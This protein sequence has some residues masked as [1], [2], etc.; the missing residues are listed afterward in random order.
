MVG[1][2][3]SALVGALH[4][5]CARACLEWMMVWKG[6]LYVIVYCYCSGCESTDCME[7]RTRAIEDSS[8][9]GFLVD[10]QDSAIL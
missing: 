8:C 10:A 5:L 6:F 2:E 7:S 4:G 9:P 1:L 3:V